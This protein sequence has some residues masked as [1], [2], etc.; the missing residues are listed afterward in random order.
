MTDKNGNEIKVGGYVRLLDV[1]PHWFEYETEEESEK[2]HKACKNP[3]PVSDI[4]DGK[5]TV[6]LPATRSDDGDMIGN[7]ISTTPDKVEVV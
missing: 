2:L 3:L 4:Y 1:Q 6:D 5:V 7:S